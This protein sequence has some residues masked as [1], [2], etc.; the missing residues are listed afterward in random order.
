[1]RVDSAVQSLVLSFMSLS[2]GLAFLSMLLKTVVNWERFNRSNWYMGNVMMI[3]IA[4][5]I[6]VLTTLMNSNDLV[7]ENA[8]S[9]ITNFNNVTTFTEVSMV[10]PL[11]SFIKA[12]QST[13]NVTDDDDD[14][15]NDDIA[16]E[17]FLRNMG[18]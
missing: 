6:S 18:K 11:Y 5:S 16:R 15:N 7:S 3:S 17:N 9:S 13:P 14:D 1:M 8:A 4:T 12:L 2:L 10:W